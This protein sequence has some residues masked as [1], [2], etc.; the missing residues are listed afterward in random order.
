MGATQ[1]LSVHDLQTI[2]G[3]T[4]PQAI[5]HWQRGETLPRI[6]NLVILADALQVKIDDFLI[7]NSR[8]TE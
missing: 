7:L 3:F 1:S 5:Y 8:D 4:A 2:L 6:D